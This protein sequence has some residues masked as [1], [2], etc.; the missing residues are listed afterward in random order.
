MDQVAKITITPRGGAG[1]LTFFAPNEDRVDSGT[2]V[3]TYTHT[4]THTHI[5][6]TYISL[7]RGRSRRRLKTSS[8]LRLI[9]PKPNILHRNP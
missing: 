2:Y 9:E 1:G 3:R 5:I 6:H 4:H 7:V 8:A